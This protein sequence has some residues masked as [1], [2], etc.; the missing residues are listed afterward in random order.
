MF[1]AVPALETVDVLTLTAGPCAECGGNHRFRAATAEAPAEPARSLCGFF[2]RC[3]ET[4]RRAW[5][6]GSLPADLPVPVRL[7]RVGPADDETWTPEVME[8]ST[9]L[10]P[11]GLSGFPS[12]G[13]ESGGFRVSSLGSESLRRALGCPHT[14]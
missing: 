11:G 2:E 5:F 6:V 12:R 13:M 8:E 14:R 7:L 1:A 10:P 9:W 3:P 4:G